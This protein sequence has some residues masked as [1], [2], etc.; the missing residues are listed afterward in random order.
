[1]RQLFLKK[2]E[3][4]IPPTSHI[5][6][7][8]KENHVVAQHLPLMKVSID[9]D[10]K[11][12]KLN[13]D[14]TFM[15]DANKHNQESWLRVQRGRVNIET[16]I[17]TQGKINLNDPYSNGLVFPLE[18]NIKDANCTSQCSGLLILDN[19]NFNKNQINNQWH[20]SFYLYDSMLDDCEINFKLPVYQTTFNENNN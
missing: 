13:G 8:L 11:H 1:M 15:V 5:V 16:A 19:V 4:S 20:I 7:G 3:Y 18:G 9:F 14:W 6:S 10:K 17:Y 2:F 12:L